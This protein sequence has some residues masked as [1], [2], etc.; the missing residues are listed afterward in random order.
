MEPEQQNLNGKLAALESLLFIH[1]EPL[2]F[3]KI[4]KKLGLRAGEVEELSS[5]LEKRLLAEDR[6]LA[7]IS[8]GGKV[9]LA[10]KAQFRE[11]LENFVKE[12]L[13]E[14]LTPASLEAL[15]VIAYLGSISRSRLDYLRG[16]NSTFI[17]RSL[18]LRGLI[19]RF[20]DPGQ[21]Q[22]YLY[23]PSLELVKH[24]GL[25]RKEDLPDYE[26]FQSLLRSFESATEEGTPQSGPPVA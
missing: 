3:D 20:P 6:G 5:E 2:G 11:I 4:E 15:S 18:L 26:K 14:E 8:G 23:E 25:R 12:E 21:P 17:L 19:Q 24:L 22:S 10:T 16:V 13:T 1:G 9:Q 7:L